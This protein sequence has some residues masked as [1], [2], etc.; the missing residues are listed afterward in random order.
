MEGQKK[1]TLTE[2]YLSAGVEEHNSNISNLATALRYCDAAIAEAQEAISA[3]N[4]LKAEIVAE[5]SKEKP[6]YARVKSLYD[7]SRKFGAAI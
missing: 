1:I 6:S 2:A 4:G 3:A 7:R 5:G